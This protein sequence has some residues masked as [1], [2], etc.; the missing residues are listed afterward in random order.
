MKVTN[1]NHCLVNSTQTYKFEKSG[2]IEINNK[3][4]HID[5]GDTLKN[6]AEKIKKEHPL[7][8]AYVINNTLCLKS[9]CK[10]NN[11]TIIDKD[12]LLNKAINQSINI[13]IIE[14]KTVYLFNSEKAKK[15]RDNYEKDIVKNNL[16]ADKLVEEKAKAEA[17]KKGKIDVKV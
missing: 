2:Y 17:I 15:A 5:K 16:L 8:N 1:T 13:P 3:I 4:I 12:N 10:N 6:L 9:I 14:E 11:I 7:I